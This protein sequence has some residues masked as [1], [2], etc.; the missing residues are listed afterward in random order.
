MDPNCNCPGIPWSQILFIALAVFSGLCL[1]VGG[2]SLKKFL[3]TKTIQWVDRKP[4]VK[5]K[6][7]KDPC[8]NYG[9]AIAALFLV[10]IAIGIGFI[11]YLVTG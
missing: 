3:S 9:P 6:P 11:F 8:P 7:N 2:F 4:K 5:D 10:T 1:L